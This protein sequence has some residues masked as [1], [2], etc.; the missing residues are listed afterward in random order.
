MDARI[1][2]GDKLDEKGQLRNI[3]DEEVER[4]NRN[5]TVGLCIG[6]FRALRERTAGIWASARAFRCL[7]K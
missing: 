6:M 1:R 5:C 4:P 2:C 3:G 7:E